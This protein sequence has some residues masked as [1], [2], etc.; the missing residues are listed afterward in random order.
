MDVT[1]GDPPQFIEPLAKSYIA[2]LNH[3]IG[4]GLRIQYADARQLIVRCARS[5][6]RSQDKTAKHANEFTPPHGRFPAQWSIF[7]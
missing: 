4:F 6:R 5:G 1:T 3:R 7:R 2:G